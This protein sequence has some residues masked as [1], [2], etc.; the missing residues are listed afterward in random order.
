MPSARPAPT[1][2]KFGVAALADAGAARLAAAIGA[3]QRGDPGAPLPT[4]VVVSAMHG[5]TDTLLG[6]AQRVGHAP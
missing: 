6:A 3:A 5:V 2:H 1:V 4:V